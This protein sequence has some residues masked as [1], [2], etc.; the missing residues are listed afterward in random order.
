MSEVEDRM[1][2]INE[3]EWKKEKRI[4]K[5]NEDNFRDFQDNVKCPKI[6][7]IGVPKEEDIKKDLAKILEIIAESLPKMGKEIIT[8][9]QKTQRVPNINPR[10]NTPRYILI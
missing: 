10:R 2:E 7:I 5:K 9:V 6:Q 4:K 8:Q 3:T 1:V